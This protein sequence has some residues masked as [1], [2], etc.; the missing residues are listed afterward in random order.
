MED[1]KQIWMLT[2][3]WSDAVRYGYDTQQHSFFKTEDGCIKETLRLNALADGYGKVIS[4]KMWVE[5][6][7][8]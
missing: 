1:L 6:L 7:G 8:D 3:T 2:I 5:A 4:H